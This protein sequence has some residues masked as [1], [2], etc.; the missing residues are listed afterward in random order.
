[1]VRPVIDLHDNPAVD[2]YEIPDPIAR[3]VRLRH[4]YD[5][6]PW[7]SRTSRSLDLDHTQPY[8]HTPDAPPGQTC[9]DNLGPLTRRAHRAKTHNGWEIAQPFPGVFDWRSP[10]GYHYRVDHTG[11]QEL[12]HPKKTKTDPPHPQPHPPDPQPHPPDS[13]P[14]QPV[15]IQSQDGRSRRLDILIDLDFWGPEAA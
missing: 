4:P 15:Q 5:I 6:F 14:E 9:P 8:D 7:S 1:V 10:L 12:P 11:S 2:S 13:R 3:I